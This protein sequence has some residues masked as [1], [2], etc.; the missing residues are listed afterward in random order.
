[1][2]CTRWESTVIRRIQLTRIL[3][4][5]LHRP[6][7]VLHC[8][9]VIVL[10]W[11]PLPSQAEQSR[12][13]TIAPSAQPGRTVPVQRCQHERVREQKC[14]HSTTGAR[15]GLEHRNLSA[16]QTKTPQ[17][18]LQFYDLGFMLLS[19]GFPLG[20][21]FPLWGSDPFHNLSGWLFLLQVLCI[22]V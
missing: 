16:C 3:Y 8:S 17:A 18:I 6:Q 7:G 13:S 5:W 1:M 19:F 2:G 15:T 14:C 9:P 4:P 11:L 20:C 21:L 10:L 12:S 22:H